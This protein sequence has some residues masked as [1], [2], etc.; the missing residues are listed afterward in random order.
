M[1]WHAPAERLAAAAS[2]RWI[3]NGAFTGLSACRAARLPSRRAVA[4]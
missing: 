1:T 3:H 2:L 4:P